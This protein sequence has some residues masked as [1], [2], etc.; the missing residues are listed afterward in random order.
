[1]VLNS[2]RGEFTTQ[3]LGLL[4]PGGRFVEIGIRD[5]KSRE[6]VAA[7]APGVRYEAIDLLEVYQQQPEVI[8]QILGQVVAA[9]A[10]GELTPLPSRVFPAE[11]VADAL[12]LMQQAKHTG[13]L[14]LSFAHPPTLHFHATSR[15]PSRPWIERRANPSGD[16]GR[17][18]LCS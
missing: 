1:M 4:R 11:A 12:R 15:T 10:A 13:K 18:D 6:E 7:L 3:S 5:V 14:V 17:Y 2:L 16:G 8:G 9:V